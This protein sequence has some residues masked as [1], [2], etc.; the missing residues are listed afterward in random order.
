ML[1]VTVAS[2]GGT[3]MSR[4]MPPLWK[5]SIFSLPTAAVSHAVKHAP[6][7]SGS[8]KITLAS[9]ATAVYVVLSTLEQGLFDDNAFVLRPGAEHERTVELFGGTS[10]AAVEALLRVE[11]LA[12]Y[13][14]PPPPPP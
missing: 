7:S 9:N 8:V 11:H 3:A 13:T 10:S 5:A 2:S 1:D 6:A 12:M 4:S 14:M